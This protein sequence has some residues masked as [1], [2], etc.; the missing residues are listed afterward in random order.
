M[1]ETDRE[2]KQTLDAEYSGACV[3][4]WGQLPLSLKAKLNQTVLTWEFH[5]LNV[6][7]GLSL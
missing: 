5:V 1:Q 2:S 3:I 4:G 7:F 6:S